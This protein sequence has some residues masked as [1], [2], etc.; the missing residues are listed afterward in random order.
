VQSLLDSLTANDTFIVNA[1]LPA[2]PEIR[3]ALQSLR[4]K[5]GVARGVATTL[6]FGPRY[7]HSTG[8][9]QKGGPNRVAGVHLWQSA[10]ARPA[11]ALAIPGIGG[12]FDLLAEAQAVGDYN[13]L[14]ERDRRI[15]G[16]DVG[17]DPAATIA[18]LADLIDGA[19]A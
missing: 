15:L 7:L 1:F 3:D 19:L 5:V 2:T 9:L 12:E 10:A 6:D 14:A 13:V 4:E 18:R 8:Q 16:I 17:A 11:A